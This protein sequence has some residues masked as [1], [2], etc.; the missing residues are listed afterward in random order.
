M[1]DKKEEKI[2]V[3]NRVMGC[4]RCESKTKK[5]EKDFCIPNDA[6]LDD[7]TNLNM[8]KFQKQKGILI[9]EKYFT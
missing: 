8:C 6:Y 1:Q 3:M 9:N 5:D 4:K 2:W 7:I